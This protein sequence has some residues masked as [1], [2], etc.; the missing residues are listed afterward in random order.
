MN[1]LVVVHLVGNCMYA[2]L[3]LNLRKICSFLPNFFLASMERI[4]KP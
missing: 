3:N 1:W 2:H 4:R